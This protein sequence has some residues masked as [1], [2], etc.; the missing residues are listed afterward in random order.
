MKINWKTFLVGFAA[1]FLGELLFG[2]TEGWF[3][4]YLYGGISYAVWDFI[5]EISS[6]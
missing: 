2:N 5:D 6:T 4:I 1:Y 3:W